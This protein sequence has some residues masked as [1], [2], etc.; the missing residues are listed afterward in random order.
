MGLRIEVRVFGR[1]DNAQ[2]IYFAY[3]GQAKEHI[4]MPNATTASERDELFITI[5]C[6]FIR[7]PIETFGDVQFLLSQYLH[8]TTILNFS[9]AKIVQNE[10]NTK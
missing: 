9:G 3:L 1:G 4:I 8:L 2:F 5:D 10:R 7:K 6:Q